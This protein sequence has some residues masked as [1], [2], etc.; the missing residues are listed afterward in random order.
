MPDWRVL[1]FAAILTFLAASFFG[2]APAFKSP[3]SA[4]TRPSFVKFSSPRRLLQAASSWI[5]AALLVRATQHVIYTDPGFGYEQLIS[6]DP[7]LGK[8][9]YSSEAARAY[10]QQMQTRLRSVPGITSVSLVGC[11]DGPHCLEQQYRNQRPQCDALSELGEPGFF[12]T[13]GIPL[14]TGRTFMPGEKHA[15]IVSESFARQQWP[16]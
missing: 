13:M 2:L 14:K 11:P 3:V 9:G 4:S 15:V 8:H 10:L 16:A 7:Q 5:V 1:L 6:I 12:A